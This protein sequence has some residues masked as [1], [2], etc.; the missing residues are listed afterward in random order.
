LA[1]GKPVIKISYDERAL[2]MME[3]IGLGQWNINMISSNNI[4]AQVSDRYHRIGDLKSLCA[5]RKPEWDNL[6]RT[7]SDAFATF[8]TETRSYHAQID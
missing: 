6:Y 2:S 3:T 5:R 7:M 4:S 1:F 8:A